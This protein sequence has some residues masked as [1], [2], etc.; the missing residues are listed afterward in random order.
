MDAGKGRLRVGVACGQRPSGW[1]MACLE[2]LAASGDAEAVV[3]ARAEGLPEGLAALPRIDLGDEG[4]VAG[5]DV[6]LALVPVDAGA[7]ARHGTWVFRLGR[8]GRRP[9]LA[10][11]PELA[12]GDPLV[13]VRVE[14]HTESGPRPVL[15]ETVLATPPGVKLARERILAECAPLLQRA[16]RRTA[17]GQPPTAGVEEPAWRPR[18]LDVPKAWLR[19]GLAWAGIVF[20]VL[21][22]LEM[23]RIGVTERSV[24]DIVRSGELGPVRWL[25]RTGRRRFHADPFAL[26]E[27]G[28][29]HVLAEAYDH[30]TGKGTIEAI[31]LERDGRWRKALQLDVHLSYPFLLRHEGAV[32]CLPE[33]SESGAAPRLRATDFP[34]GWQ[35]VE[36]PLIDAPLIDP[37]VCEHDGRFWLFAARADD[38]PLLRLFVWHG[39]GPFGPWT[40]HALSPVLCDVRRARP[41]GPLFRAHGDL[42]RPAQDSSRTYG[43]GLVLNRVL[44][45][46]PEVF[47]EEM[48]AVLRPDPLG[49]CPDGVHHICPA[50][51]VAVVDGKR[52]R[53]DP[54]AWLLKRR[55][56]RARRARTRA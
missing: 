40:P 10:G 21:F 18:A 49:P 42:I 22:K 23:W 12:A 11:L 19:V 52:W 26:E 48:A 9:G 6:L 7:G 50:G 41:A 35:P 25:P 43:G 4:A 51:H 13:H 47:E 2:A 27:G 24:A 44:A 20:E 37:T 33:A 14:R 32:W 46:T 39:P 5:L 55:L 30:A 54:L 15:A 17:L 28:R 53:I 31:A 8:A 34:T 16:L 1:Q 38:E 3:D 56:K 36:P 45:L 29:M